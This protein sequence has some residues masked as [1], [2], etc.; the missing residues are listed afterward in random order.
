MKQPLRL[1]VVPSSPNSL[2]SSSADHGQHDPEQALSNVSRLDTNASNADRT[3]LTI[4]QWNINGQLDRYWNRYPMLATQINDLSPDILCFQEAITVKWGRYGTVNMAKKIYPRYRGFHV[5]PY[6]VLHDGYKLC[7]QYSYIWRVILETQFCCNLYCLVPFW[8]ASL[9]QYAVRSNACVRACFKTYTGIL[10]QVG[11]AMLFRNKHQL[12]RSYLP[13][14]GGNG[15]MLALRALYI[16]N[17]DSAGAQHKKAMSSVADAVTAPAEQDVEVQELLHT[18]FKHNNY[19]QRLSLTL[20]TQKKNKNK[21]RKKVWVVSTKLSKD[22]R[23]IILNRDEQKEKE[24]EDMSENE[25]GQLDV[26]A[27]ESHVQ[28]DNVALQQLQQIMKWMNEA[29]K[30]ICKADAIVMCMDANATPNSEVYEFMLRNGYKSA[31]QQFNGNEQWTY[32]TET[33]QFARNQDSYDRAKQQCAKDYIFYREFDTKITVEKVRLVGRQYVDA[34]HR[35]NKIKVYPSDH[36]GVYCAL[37][38]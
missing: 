38:L 31:M 34:H 25:N 28:G 17:D 32:P 1:R 35:G 24:K 11:N 33:W 22:A 23:N 36:L 20:S 3:R 7:F 21:K 2:H 14:K 5:S 16:M 6:N 19:G 13:L 8:R 10:A 18:K 30:T 15:E 37:Y 27:N 12:F 29:Q 26:N 4:L 9:W